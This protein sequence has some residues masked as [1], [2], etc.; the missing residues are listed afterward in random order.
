MHSGIVPGLRPEIVSDADLYRIAGLVDGLRDAARELLGHE[1][2]PATIGRMT[3]RYRRLRAALPATLSPESAEQLDAWTEALTDQPAAVDEV[4]DAAAHLARWL[5]MIIGLPGFMVAR[6]V[7]SAEL[8][9][10]LSMLPPTSGTPD[11]PRESREGQY[12]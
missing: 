1:V 8:Q 9:E 7:E 12:L 11:S 10:R 4:F 5:D 3:T 2:S 6:R